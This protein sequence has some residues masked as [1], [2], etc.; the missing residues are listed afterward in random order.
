MPSWI[1]FAEVQKK[2]IEHQM[3]SLPKIE[4]ELEFS[5]V[6]RQ[7]LSRHM[8]VRA[9]DRPLQL[10]PDALKRVGVNT[11]AIRMSKG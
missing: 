2:P 10:R 9:A 11:D 8:N 6:L 4:A 7:M 1:L 5:K 3:R